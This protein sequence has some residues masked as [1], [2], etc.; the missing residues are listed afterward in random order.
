MKNYWSHPLKNT[1][2]RAWYDTGDTTPIYPPVLWLISICSDPFIARRVRS[3]HLALK[4]PDGQSP[5]ATIATLSGITAAS[6]IQELFI[7]WRYDTLQDQSV[8]AQLQSLLDRIWYMRAPS[9][10]K[11]VVDSPIEHIYPFTFQ[12]IAAVRLQELE[13]RFSVPF[14]HIRRGFVAPPAN[15]TR[16][17]EILTNFVAPFINRH[18]ST[19][20]ALSISSGPWGLD[21]S[22][23]FN[24]LGELPCIARL[25]VLVAFNHAGLSDPSGL[26]RLF[27]NNHAT[28]KHVKLQTDTLRSSGVEKLPFGHWMSENCGDPTILSNLA[29]LQVV[30]PMPTAAGMKLLMPYIR[31]SADTLT[32]LAVRGLTLTHE[33]VGGLAKLFIH[34]PPQQRLQELEITVSILSITLLELMDATLPSVETLRLDFKNLGGSADGEPIPFVCLVTS[35]K[36]ILVLTFKTVCV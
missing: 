6:N 2:V 27:H 34:R 17:S 33:E 1:F 7:S 32:V 10:R 19:L 30:S 22:P 23:L 24:S 18:A 8:I 5:T 9:L 14:S 4:I 12:T 36:K 16:D 11:L 15:L 13:L 25:N 3:L 29:T 28:I 20:R 21:L 31:R 35:F 26:T